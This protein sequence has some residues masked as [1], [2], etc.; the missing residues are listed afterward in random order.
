LAINHPVASQSLLAPP[1]D[2]VTV[3]ESEIVELTGTV[4]VAAPSTV[5]ESITRAAWASR[6]KSENI[7][8][9]PI[10]M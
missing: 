10:R 3:N 6:V 4:V 2:V 5:A 1:P 7:N 9:A 8:A